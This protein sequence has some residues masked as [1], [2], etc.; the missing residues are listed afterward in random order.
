[1]ILHSFLLF[2]AEVF[3]TFVTLWTPQKFQARVA[4]PTAQSTP[5]S[6]LRTPGW[7]R[8]CDRSPVFLGLPA[9][10]LEAPGGPPVVLGPQVENPWFTGFVEN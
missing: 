10:P 8:T 3:T 2:T 4:D 7:A 9:D 5:A 1:M 6:T